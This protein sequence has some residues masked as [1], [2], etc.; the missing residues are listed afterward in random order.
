MHTNE[1]FRYLKKNTE[2]CKR[3]VIINRS[4]VVSYKTGA[5]TAL[6]HAAGSVCME[7]PGLK[8]NF[9]KGTKY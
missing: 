9:S 5:I 2:N 4:F 8:I 6:F 1:K 7:M 3:P